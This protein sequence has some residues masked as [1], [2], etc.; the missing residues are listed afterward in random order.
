MNVS[1]MFLSQVFEF[2]YLN[3]LSLE[4]WRMTGMPA[5]SD[6]QNKTA[7]DIEALELLS[8]KCHVRRRRKGRGV[9]RVSASDSSLLVALINTHRLADS[10][11]ASSISGHLPPRHRHLTRKKSDVDSI[12]GHDS[13]HAKHDPKCRVLW[14]GAFWHGK[15][16]SLYTID[17]SINHQPLLSN[18]SSS[19]HAFKSKYLRS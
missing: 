12:M 8:K 1:C 10:S 2:A 18:I 13:W 6:K 15:V 4:P 11:L 5:L 19:E 7:W 3:L 17:F 14:R 9:I 16:S